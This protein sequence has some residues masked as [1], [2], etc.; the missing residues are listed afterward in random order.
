M[1]I[2]EQ[3]DIAEK[4]STAQLS[5]QCRF[6]AQRRVGTLGGCLC[7]CCAVPSHSLQSAG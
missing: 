4:E 7:S 3:L 2:E 1:A 5:H 6:E